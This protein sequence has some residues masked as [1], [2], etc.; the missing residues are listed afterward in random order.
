MLLALACW[1]LAAA[2]PAAEGFQ[3]PFYFAKDIR[4]TV[5][6]ERA[7]VR[8]G[9]QPLE[10]EGAAGQE[11]RIARGEDDL[12]VHTSLAAAASSSPIAATPAGSSTSVKSMSSGSSSVTR[13]TV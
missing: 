8:V 2:V 11:R 1:T 3:P 13:F 7:P 12:R 6:D 9:G 5:V 4:A 10:R